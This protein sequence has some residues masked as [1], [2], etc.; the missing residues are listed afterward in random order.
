MIPHRSWFAGAVAAAVTQR[1]VLFPP[2]RIRDKVMIAASLEVADRV[3]GGRSRAA[4]CRQLPWAGPP[5]G[6]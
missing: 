2:Q 3:A 1:R 6:A 4:H 5:V